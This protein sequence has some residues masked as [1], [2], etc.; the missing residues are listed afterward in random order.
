MSSS[1]CSLQRLL[2]LWMIVIF[3]EVLSSSQLVQSQME[4]LTKSVL[5]DQDLR[6]VKWT[7]HVSEQRI[8]NPNISCKITKSLVENSIFDCLKLFISWIRTK[9][10]HSWFCE[11]WLLKVE[12]KH[13]DCFDQEHGIDS[14]CFLVQNNRSLSLSIFISE[15]SELIIVG[16]KLSI[17][18]RMG[19]K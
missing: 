5:L 18:Q 3:Q 11:K 13:L 10:E 19:S 14:L 1:V 6:G 16:F 7:N 17:L 4:E 9:N 2:Y 12:L 8:R 15:E